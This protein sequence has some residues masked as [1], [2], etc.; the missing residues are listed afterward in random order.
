M[1]TESA[2]F[3]TDN[4]KDKIARY[5]NMLLAISLGDLVTLRCHIVDSLCGAFCEGISLMINAADSS[6][7]RLDREPEFGIRKAILAAGA[8][9]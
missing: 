8:T 6:F 7:W 1:T 9:R 3:I 5:L 4:H 2:V